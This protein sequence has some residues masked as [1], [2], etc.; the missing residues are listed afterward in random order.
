[1]GGSSSKSSLPLPIDL[2]EDF[3]ALVATGATSYLETLWY[4]SHATY[5]S[6]PIVDGSHF[7]RA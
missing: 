3:C 4:A 5:Q 7:D 2:I 1:M 6:W